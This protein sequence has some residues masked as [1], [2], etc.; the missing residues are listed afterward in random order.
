MSCPICGDDQCKLIPCEIPWKGS[1]DC[2]PT[3]G[4]YISCR[5]TGIE[6]TFCNSI[7][8]GDKAECRRR[9]SMMCYITLNEPIFQPDQNK[10]LFYY[11]HD[12]NDIASFPEINLAKRMNVYPKDAYEK[13]HYAFRNLSSIKNKL[14]NTFINTPLLYVLLFCECI[15]KEA[16]QEVQGIYSFLVDLGYIK[17]IPPESYRISSKGWEYI[18]QLKKEMLNQGFIAMEFSDRAESIADTFIKT[19]ED[20]CGYHAKIMTRKEHNNQIVPEI[21]YEI[22]RSK[23]L[24]VDVTF[25]NY[26]AYYEAGY[27]EALGKQVIVCCREKEFTSNEKSEKPHFDIAQKAAVVWTDEADL[28]ERLYRR[29]EATVGLYK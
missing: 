29:I 10:Y 6:F 20:R 14:S 26:G 19:I 2:F 22:K 23:F 27:G 15:T 1:H 11:R 7:Y 9:F 18:H 3:I 28:E 4:S 16:T 13:V 24:V 5:N 25:P 17:L 12:E 21:M 8:D